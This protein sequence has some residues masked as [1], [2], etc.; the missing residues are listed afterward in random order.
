[1]LVTPTSLVVNSA[2]TFIVVHMTPQCK[3]YIILVKKWLK[4]VCHLPVGTACN[5]SEK[6]F[7]PEWAAYLTIRA[8]THQ[9]KDAFDATCQ[10]PGAFSPTVVDPYMGR[11]PVKTINGV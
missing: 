1:M 10:C 2:S 3:G 4:R 11:C 6:D 9:L 5:T 8:T 7:A